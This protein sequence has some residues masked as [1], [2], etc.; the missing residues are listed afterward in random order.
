MNRKD[1]LKFSA[2]LTAGLGISNAVSAESS[3]A[4][5]YEEGSFKQQSLPYSYD[6]LA[7][8]VDA[9]T[10]E[11]HY[12][13]HAAAYCKNLNSAVL[14]SGMPKGTT[15]PDLMKQISKYPPVIRNNGGGHFNHDFFWNCMQPGGSVLSDEQLLSFIQRDFGA[16]QTLKEKFSEAALKLFGSGWAWMILDAQQKL[17]IV[18]TPNQDNPLMDIVPT[19]GTPLL[20]LDVWE[21][22]YY[23]HYQNRRAEYISNWWNIVNWK[24]VAT[25]LKQAL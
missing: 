3:V 18:T 14:Q 19:K 21:H 1:F 7:P 16:E 17:Q 2:V 20:A 24:W 11:L 22:A 10:M 4:P 25:C 6:A 5:A 23:L 12:S 9:N 15:L 8:Y 13:K